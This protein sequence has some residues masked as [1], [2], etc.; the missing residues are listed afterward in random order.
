MIP[1][2]PADQ[3]QDGLRV[4]E[5]RRKFRSRRHE[6][7]LR[8][9][10]NWATLVILLL[11]STAG[12]ATHLPVRRR[13]ERRCH[14]R[15]PDARNSRPAPRRDLRR[16]RRQRHGRAGAHEPLPIRSL[17]LMGLLEVVPKIFMLKA[18]LKRTVAD[19]QARRP[20]ILVTI[21]SPGFTLRVLKA[22]QPTTL[23]RVHYVAPQVW[24]WRR[25]PGQALPRPVGRTAVPAAVRARV[26]RPPRPHREIRRSSSL[27]KR[28][29]H[30]QRRPLP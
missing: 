13:A 1:R 23:K 9:L 10:G 15:R 3:K 24:A 12:H 28:C 17:A 19:I 21:N 14:R 25:E 7:H 29:R 30:R 11:S 2:P 18:L 20:D 22:L 26:L 5:I 27:G 8:R 4:I 6:W 16:R